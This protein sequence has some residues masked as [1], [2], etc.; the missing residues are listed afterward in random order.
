MVQDGAALARQMRPR[1]KQAL[2]AKGREKRRKK[3]R[4]SRRDAQGGGR[5]QMD[6][7]EREGEREKVH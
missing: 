6:R 1:V 7:T 2:Q 5:N 4:Q 3:K